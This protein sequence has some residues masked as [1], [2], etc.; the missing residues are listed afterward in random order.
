MIADEDDPNISI[1]IF[2]YCN[3]SVYMASIHYR[4]G[5]EVGAG[6]ELIM[7][8]GSHA[9]NADDFILKVSAG[10]VIDWDESA[11]T[12]EI[13][14]G[15][16]A[17]TSALTIDAS[18]GVNFANPPT[19][20]YPAVVA[21][22]IRAGNTQIYN[23][24]SQATI[25]IHSVVTKDTWETVGPTG[26]GADNIWTALDNIPANATALIIKINVQVSTTGTSTAN[27]DVFATDGD[28][29][30]GP[31]VAANLLATVVNDQDAAISGN[32]GGTSEVLIPLE[33]VN[34]DF[35]I[36]WTSS[37]A[38]GEFIALYYKG[39]MTD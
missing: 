10:T 23:G 1:Y 22:H 9:T 29:V 18:Q 36:R 30:E 27:H 34:Q 32:M 5:G 15:V 8:G 20:L 16:G 12:L 35:R 11:G 39:F 7:W 6:A 4:S 14:T 25:N 37:D 3:T 31:L 2:R 21:D 13:L 33:A 38:D 28:S 17:K 19:G 24:G 26:S